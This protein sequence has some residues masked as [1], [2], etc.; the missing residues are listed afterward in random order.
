MGMSGSNE[1]LHQFQQRTTS[2]NTSDKYHS[3]TDAKVSKD[4]IQQ[5]LHVDAAHDL[6]ERARRLSKLLRGQHQILLAV[7]CGK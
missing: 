3:F 1:V 6:A 7:L 4:H 5:L 2:H